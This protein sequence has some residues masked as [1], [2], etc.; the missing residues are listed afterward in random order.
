MV[1]MVFDC[2]VFLGKKDYLLMFISIVKVITGGN[3]SVYM[4]FFR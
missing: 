2:K 3:F 4:E 1:F